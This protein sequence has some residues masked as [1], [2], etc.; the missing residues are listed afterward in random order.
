MG[1]G[2]PE[3]AQERLEGHESR[4]AATVAEGRGDTAGD[5]T[6][7]AT[8]AR[9]HFWSITAEDWEALKRVW[10]MGRSTDGR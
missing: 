2:T 3:G 10:D 9:E 4:S 5:G 6:E 7:T 1:T 8:V